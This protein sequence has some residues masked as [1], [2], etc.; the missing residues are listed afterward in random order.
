MSVSEG[1]E[2]TTLSETLGA[3]TC[4]DERALQFTRG[5]GVLLCK[6]TAQPVPAPA[7][8]ATLLGEQCSSTHLRAMS[9]FPAPRGNRAEQMGTDT[10][11]TRKRYAGIFRARYAKVEGHGP[12]SKHQQTLSDANPLLREPSFTL[13]PPARPRGTWL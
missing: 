8:S 3:G 10:G 13:P 2:T 4:W 11:G 6:G 12:H 9:L 1:E 7:T 5:N